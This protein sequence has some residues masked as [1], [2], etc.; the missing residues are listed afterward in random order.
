MI[1]KARLPEAAIRKCVFIWPKCRSLGENGI[2]A[3]E[4]RS[5]NGLQW[6]R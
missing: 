6:S 1:K 2:V 5:D 3:R 4:S